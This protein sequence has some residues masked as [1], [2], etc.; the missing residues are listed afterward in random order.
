MEQTSNPE[1]VWQIRGKRHNRSEKHLRNQRVRK[2]DIHFPKVDVVGSIPITRSIP[3]LS[4]TA[5]FMGRPMR[6]HAF[7][8]VTRERVRP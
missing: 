8:R 4:A 7:Q 5:S 1:L 3:F 2:N 6:M